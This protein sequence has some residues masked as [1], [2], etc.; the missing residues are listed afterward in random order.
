M[1][2]VIPFL[3]RQIA[4]MARPPRAVKARGNG[5]RCSNQYFSVALARLP[6]SRLALLPGTQLFFVGDALFLVHIEDAI[7]AAAV[8]ALVIARP[9]RGF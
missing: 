7:G 3:R 5:E 8:A 9:D 2:R 4:G 1:P 6:G